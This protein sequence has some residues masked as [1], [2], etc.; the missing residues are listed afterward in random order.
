MVW[1]AVL[2]CVR[3]ELVVIVPDEVM[4]AVLVAVGRSAV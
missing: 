2:V 1:V 4:V 3:V